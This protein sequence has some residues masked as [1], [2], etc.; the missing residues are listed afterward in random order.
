MHNH[1]VR[2]AFACALVVSGLVTTIAL[3]H[4]AETSVA[5]FALTGVHQVATTT[6]AGVQVYS[7]EYGPLHRLGWALKG[8]QAT[9]YDASGLAL[10]RHEAG[11][12]W[13]AEDGSKIVGHVISQAPSL[14]P[15]SIPQLLLETKTV[16]GAGMLAEVRYVERLDTVGGSAPSGACTVEHQIGNSP[17][18]A[19]YVFWK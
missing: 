3:V 2:T 7:C 5:T 4:A 19:R 1:I 16:V 15:G 18:L 10:I 6:A 14:T 12:S 9:L 11:P 13:Q 8:P 17:Y